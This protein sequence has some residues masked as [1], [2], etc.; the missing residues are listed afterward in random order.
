MAF[1][2][3][4]LKTLYDSALKYVMEKWEERKHLLLEKY[5]IFKFV[6]FRNEFSHTHILHPIRVALLML[7]YRI[8]S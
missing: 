6:S 3:L 1:K 2:R 4:I 7:S 8:I 5:T